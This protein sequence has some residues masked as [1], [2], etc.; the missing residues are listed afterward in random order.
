MPRDDDQV[1][2]HVR[3][4][5]EFLGSWRYNFGTEKQLQ[6]GIWKL[7]QTQW[8]GTAG[9]HR[10]HALSRTDRIDFYHAP[11]CIGV[12]VKTAHGLSALTRQ[13]HG[14]VQHEAIRGLVLV[15]SKTRLTA[16]PER[17]NGKPI[18]IVNL[19]GSIL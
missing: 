4:I 5:A 6:D 8:T 13:L 19:I 11:T 10:E 1:L 7:V 18:V 9:W 2:A 17:M 12:E 3:E 16:L 15:T 14:Y